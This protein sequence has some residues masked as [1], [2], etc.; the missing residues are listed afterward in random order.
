MTDVGRL[1]AEALGI[2]VHAEQEAAVRAVESGRDVVVVAPTGW[3]K[4]AAYQLAGA[5]LDGL[6]VVVSPLLALQ[7][8]QERRLDELPLGAAATLSSHLSDAAYAENLELLR[9]GRL[10]FVLLTPEQLTNPDVLDALV[11]AKPALL[12]VDEAHL[13]VS[14]GDGF[15][16][17]FCAIGPA[18]AMLGRPPVL[19]LTASA[20]EPVLADVVARLDLA[21]PLVLRTGVERPNL[22]VAVD[23]APDGE[24][25]LD[26]LLDRAAS[27]AGTG[28]VYAAKRADAERLAG[29]LGRPDRPAFAYHAGL[30]GAAR[31]AVHERFT[32]HEPC[33]V[34]ATSAFGLGI[35]KPDVRF[36][37]HWGAPPTLDAYYQEVGRAG[38]D[39]APADAVLFW[40][41]A[42]DAGRRFTG[43]ATA[44]APATVRRLAAVLHAAARTLRLDELR[45]VVRA[46][47]GHLWQAAA[48]LHHE[49]LAELRPSGEITWRDGVDPDALGGP[50][51]RLS[52]ERRTRQRSEA[53]AMRRFLELQSCRWRAIN[54]HLGA[55]DAEPCGHCDCCDAGGGSRTDASSPW[56]VGTR[57]VHAELG[58][59]HVVDAAEG[60]VEVL[61][62]EGGYRTLATEVVEEKGLL[63]PA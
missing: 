53:V 41:P 46:K 57:V 26:A 16:P 20:S 62:D 30:R 29:R 12:T 37:L 23:V 32:H 50:L 17:A 6:V 61:F 1:A 43:G 3:G 38:R 45:P 54:G 24:A 21:D 59:G 28:L 27:L 36:V 39:G 5:V 8:D 18:A 49:E 48:L 60:Q 56:G 44:V 13:V 31:A 4:S 11:A 14:W 10:R 42:S 52:T 9:S 33:I 35:D 7:H 47:P 51:R 22:H 55:P 25:A 63:R 2:E 40:S 19:A 34:A 58:G 15:R